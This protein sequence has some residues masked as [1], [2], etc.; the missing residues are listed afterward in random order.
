MHNLIEG[1]DWLSSRKEVCFVQG[2]GQTYGQKH[3][4]KEHVEFHTH[5]HALTM[6][7]LLVAA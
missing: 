6:I 7:K 4:T 3:E 5:L 2:Q 1:F